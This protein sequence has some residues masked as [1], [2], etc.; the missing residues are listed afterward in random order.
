MA[1]Q[2][3]FI[4]LN[5]HG[6]KANISY[7]ESLLNSYDVIFLSE[8]W[9]SNFERPL[10]KN[11]SVS[12]HILFQ[13]AEKHANGRPFGGNCFLVNKDL[14][15]SFDILHQDKHIFSL[16]LTCSESPII[17]IGVY[18]TASQNNSE[19]QDEYL[20]QL[21]LI[22]AL[23]EQYA[24]EAECVVVGDFQSFPTQI[25]DTKIR[26]HPSRNILSHHLKS[27]LL[28]N[29]LDLIDIA[30]GDGPNYTYHHVSLQRQSYIDHIVVSKFSSLDTVNCGV[31]ED[32]ILNTS[33]HLPVFISLKLNLINKIN[34]QEQLNH[35]QL[36]I[37]S[38]MWKNNQFLSLYQENLQNIFNGKTYDGNNTDEQIETFYITI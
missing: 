24:D 32:Q 36:K 11:I 6:L 35:E 15:K 13:N 10:L 26:N 29:D 30:S 1:K 34:S 14:F 28:N 21:A 31:L 5:C 23:L 20:S 37:P 17:L 9:L 38:Y 3:N 4:S 16:K 8:H 18:L 12:H 7:V 19:C 22:S 2:V 27:F 33:D 25:Y